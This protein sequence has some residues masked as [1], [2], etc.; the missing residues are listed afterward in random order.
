ML[1]GARRV[2][3]PYSDLPG[4]WLHACTLRGSAA[5]DQSL[6]AEPLLFAKL[7]TS[8]FQKPNAFFF[9]EAEKGYFLSFDE[10]RVDI[11]VI[12]YR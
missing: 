9:T 5:T 10:G 2:P 8:R 11:F 4:H 7:K 6:N 3:E 12:V 1:N